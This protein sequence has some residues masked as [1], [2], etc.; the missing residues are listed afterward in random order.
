MWYGRKLY[1]WSVCYQQLVC[2]LVSLYVLV[3]FQVILGENTNTTAPRRC[4][5]VRTYLADY[6]PDAHPMTGYRY[7]NSLCDISE[8][9]LPKRL[10]S[11]DAELEILY[12]WVTDDMTWTQVDPYDRSKLQGLS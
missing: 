12:I 3:P 8:Q 5:K 10:N 9:S 11:A 1:K 2:S 6:G 7:C 4:D